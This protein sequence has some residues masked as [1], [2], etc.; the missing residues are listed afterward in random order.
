VLRT[1]TSLLYTPRGLDDIRYSLNH[2]CPI[3]DTDT[4]VRVIDT[5]ERIEYNG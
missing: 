3:S 4:R 1:I 2:E 5:I